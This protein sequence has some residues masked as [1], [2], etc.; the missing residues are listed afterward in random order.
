MST[1]QT[2]SDRLAPPLILY[3]AKGDYKF[4]HGPIR[5]QVVR[6]RDDLSDL[7]HGEWVW[8]DGIRQAVGNH[9]ALRRSWCAPRS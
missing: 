6:V 8:V 4:G 5:L 3:L 9:Q 1:P 2:Q 7:Y